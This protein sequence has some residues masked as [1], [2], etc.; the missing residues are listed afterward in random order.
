MR[1]Y[2][3]SIQRCENPLSTADPRQVLAEKF[4]RATRGGDYGSFV[5]PGPRVTRAAGGVCMAISAETTMTAAWLFGIPELQDPP[6]SY[7]EAILFELLSALAQQFQV[8]PPERTMSLGDIV[9]FAIAPVPYLIAQTVG[10]SA[11][12]TMRPTYFNLV[13]NP[14]NESVNGSVLW[15]ADGTAAITATGDRWLANSPNENPIGPNHLIDQSE[16]GLGKYA[17]Y[18]AGAAIAMSSAYVL[19][20]VGGFFS[21]KPDAGMPLYE[22]DPRRRVQTRR[23]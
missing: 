4:R 12:E 1:Y 9:G 18:F 5:G 11:Q 17:K 13:A 16:G 7:Y 2:V 10:E 19:Y 15:W 3:I 14:Y 22:E 23:R 21:P 20:K 8:T 6:P